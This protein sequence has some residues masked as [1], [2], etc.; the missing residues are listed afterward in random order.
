MS[1]FERSSVLRA[2]QR[3]ARGPSWG[4]Q[5]VKR[6]VD[7]S[8][9]RRKPDSAN[10]K[11]V[12]RFE[13]EM[14]RLTARQCPDNRRVR[15]GATGCAR[16][17]FLRSTAVRES[18]AI[19]R[20]WKKEQVARRRSGS[21]KDVAADKRVWTD[22]VEPVGKAGRQGGGRERG[23]GRSVA[24]GGGKGGG[25][26]CGVLAVS[27]RWPAEGEWSMAAAVV[28]GRWWEGTVVEQCRQCSSHERRRVA[29]Q[30]RRA[31]V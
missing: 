9:R 4:E 26:G 11:T 22:L 16:G 12:G 31:V 23:G 28:S 17:I 13:G 24:R 2:S 25:G 15:E 21:R 7:L 18:P 1:N 20:P 30:Q 27:Q 19:T 29:V 6:G 3:N 8:F 14:A 5:R 10:G